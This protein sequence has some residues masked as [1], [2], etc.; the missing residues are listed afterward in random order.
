MQ[1]LLEPRLQNICISLK[2]SPPRTTLL[3]IKKRVIGEL[4]GA[5]VADAE[6]VDVRVYC[7]CEFDGGDGGG[8]GFGVV[9]CGVVEMVG[10]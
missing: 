2:T 3:A 1:R 7:G 5:G 9:V 6:G 8:S 4:L 10:D